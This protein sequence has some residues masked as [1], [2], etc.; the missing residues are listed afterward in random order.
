MA[1]KLFHVQLPEEL[2][3]G[4]GWT[5]SDVPVHIREVLVMELLRLDRL[6]EVQ[7]ADILGL[8]RW[9]LLD[10]MGKLQVSAIRL[11]EE[12]LISELAESTSQ[13]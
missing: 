10:L 1:E 9:Q 11:S 8:D 7:A 2:L 4:F 13:L 5:E 3:D 6:S 12:D